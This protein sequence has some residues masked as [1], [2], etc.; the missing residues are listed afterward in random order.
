[1]Q[2]NLDYLHYNTSEKETLL[3][4]ISMSLLSEP[5]RLGHGPQACGAYDVYG[6]DLAY[7]CLKIRER[8]LASSPMVFSMPRRVNVETESAAGPVQGLP[9]FS[10]SARCKGH[11]GVPNVK[12]LKGHYT[13]RKNHFP[14]RC[15][16]SFLIVA[17]CVHRISF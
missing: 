17:Q 16:G 8:K 14:P 13:H 15:S 4:T 7:Y 9:W 3:F 11:I 5:L 12:P 2:R 1:M 10:T 6:V